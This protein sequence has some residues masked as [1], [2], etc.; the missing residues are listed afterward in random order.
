LWWEESELEGAGKVREGGYTVLEKELTVIKTTVLLTG[1]RALQDR[2]GSGLAY[3]EVRENG[4]EEQ[5]SESEVDMTDAEDGERS[6]R[7]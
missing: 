4:L 5:E 1:L 2:G 3:M 6:L 7:C